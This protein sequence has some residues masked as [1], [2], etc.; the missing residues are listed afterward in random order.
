MPCLMGLRI[1]AESLFNVVL[2][3][4]PTAALDQATGLEVMEIM[5]RLNRERH[6]TFIFSSHDPEV[7]RAADRVMFLRD[8]KVTE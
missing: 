4:E 1:V 8:G 2:A 3:D 7:L 6:V 5:K